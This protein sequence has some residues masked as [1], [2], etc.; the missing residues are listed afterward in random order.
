[1]A[2]WNLILRFFLE[3]WV[4]GVVF[5]AALTVVDGGWR[6]VVA[7]AASLVLITMWGVFNVPEDPSR[8]GRAP[9]PVPGWARLSIE[10]FYFGIGAYA[11]YLAGWPALALV[12][13]VVVIVHYVFSARRVRWLIAR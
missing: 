2:T 10:V 1:M 7:V 12:F 6:I 5:V 11:T 3:I 4:L 8:S 9:V 13:S